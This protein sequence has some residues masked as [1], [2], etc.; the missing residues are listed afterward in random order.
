[1]SL[2]PK[3]V[4]QRLRNSLQISGWPIPIF[5]STNYHTAHGM[6]LFVL[7][8]KKNCTGNDRI[9]FEN[10]TCF[11]VKIPLQMQS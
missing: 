4:L 1:M 11:R 8:Q 7:I 3:L 6:R 9:G 5:S 2:N 10:Y